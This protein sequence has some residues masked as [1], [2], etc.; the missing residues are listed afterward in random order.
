MVAN[1]KCFYY[2][3]NYMN[4]SHFAREYHDY[5]RLAS[6]LLSSLRP[7]N[8][9]RNLFVL[10]PLLF[11]YFQTRPTCFIRAL[12]AFLLFALFSGGLY[13]VNDIRDQN[14]DALHPLKAQRPIVSGELPVP[15]AV[16]FFFALEATVA[17]A[18]FALSSE[19]GL[20]LSLY[21]A[22]MLLY[23]FALKNLLGVDVLTLSLGFVLRTV[24][25]AAV[26]GLNPQPFLMLWVFCLALFLAL[27]KRS[28]DQATLEGAGVAGFS[29]RVYGPR[30]L[31]SALASTAAA[32]IVAYA[33]FAYS[34][35]DRRFL[36]TVPFVAFGALSYLRLTLDAPPLS[37]P[38][39]LLWK[40]PSLMVNNLLWLTVCVVINVSRP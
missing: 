38:D 21:G 25:G 15:L 28:M 10:G 26:L 27:S 34:L 9:G 33:L 11:P 32:T 22:L 14:E 35:G 29:A 8:W 40:T 18:S 39:Q 16:I 31:R 17:L 5:R 36:Y 1:S 20:V 37:T 30:L 3:S 23:S 13:I 2:R 7:K 4:S 12:I 19:F 24:A 6:S